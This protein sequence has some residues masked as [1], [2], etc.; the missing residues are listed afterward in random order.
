MAAREKLDIRVSC[1]PDGFVGIAARGLPA[2]AQGLTPTPFAISMPSDF[3][4]NLADALTAT[5]DVGRAGAVA[6]IPPP[7]HRAYHADGREFRVW[8]P[9]RHRRYADHVMFELAATGTRLGAV[10]P[11]WLALPLDVARSTARA[12]RQAVRDAEA[13]VRR[14]TALHEA[15]HAVAAVWH[16]IPLLRLELGEASTER[17]GRT[18]TSGGRS[19]IDPTAKA[20][21]YG[22]PNDPAHRER[23]TAYARSIAAGPAAD[24]L[25]GCAPDDLGASGDWQQVFT[26]ALM[27]G[28]GPTAAAAGPLVWH[29]GKAEIPRAL[30]ARVTQDPEVQA[31][32]DARLQEATG[33]LRSS[34]ADTWHR[35]A[36]ELE[37]RGRLT[38]DQVRA[39]VTA[40]AGDSAVT[41][42]RPR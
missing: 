26:I 19:Q 40:G 30:L 33:L 18:E 36:D 20:Q 6:P 13:Q 25:N 28:I 4:G 35:L 38:G 12:L 39:L 1:Q 10:C 3:A 32:A 17:N 21:W 24:Q 27:L 15:A 42:E 2:G 23:L 37:R 29:D 22:A 5:A 8:R 7:V 31:W 9:V 16:H 14:L 41:A 11:E 34:L